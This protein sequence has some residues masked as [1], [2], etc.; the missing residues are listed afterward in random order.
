M[1][2][3]KLTDQS[4]H[5][6]NMETA[7][8]EREVLTRM[9]HRL[10]ETE[11]RRLYSKYNCQSLFEYA[12]KFLQYSNDQADRRI[13][14]MRILRDVP[15]I[16]EKISAGALTL[17]NLALAQKLFT[18][19]KKT[20]NEFTLE[21]KTE[22]LIKLE[23]QTTRA[24]E[25]IVFE[26]K[27]ELKPSRKELNF[28]DIEDDRLREKLLQVK[29][30]FAHKEPNMTLPELLHKL[31]DQELSKK[32]TVG[33]APRVES[34]T[35]VSR[36]PKID[37]KAE[38]RRQVWRRDQGKCRKCGS[39]HA[40]QIEHLQP[41]AVGGGFTLDNLCLLCRSCNQRSAIE[42]FGMNKMDQFLKSPV[43]PYGT[44]QLAPADFS[45]GWSVDRRAPD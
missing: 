5:D 28:S 34:K 15:E 6:G 4:L 9:L 27:P 26:I 35:T 33:R 29:G 8:E 39:R 18:L 17:T 32:N 31:C 23:N 41:K 25:K 36:A 3:K 2:L 20:G 1:D 24:A 11:R 38:I 19:E 42:Y 10:R 30:L 37:S 12:V 16:E 14:A 7:R 21:Q 44:I 40:L 43:Q 45:P 13:K 22:V